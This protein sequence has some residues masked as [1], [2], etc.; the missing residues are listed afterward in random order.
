MQLLILSTQIVLT[1]FEVVSELKQSDALSLILFNV[2]IK[3]IEREIQ[4]KIIME[5]QF[6]FENI[7]MYGFAI[8]LNLLCNVIDNV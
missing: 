1:S 5:T 6:Y 3:K 4:E 7:K 8:D 2:K